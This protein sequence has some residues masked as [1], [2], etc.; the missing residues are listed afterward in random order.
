M[1]D[2]SNFTAGMSSGGTRKKKKSDDDDEEEEEEET[3]ASKMGKAGA[4]G[5]PWA[6]AAQGAANVISAKAKRQKERSKALMKSSQEQQA[7]FSKGAQ[8]M[9]SIAQNFRL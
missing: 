4:M 6:A 2:F 9:A 8:N 1:I 7:N 5:G 3:G